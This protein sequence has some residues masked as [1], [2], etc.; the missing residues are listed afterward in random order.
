MN[1]KTVKQKQSKSMDMRFY[2][3]QDRVEQGQFRIFWAP[4]KTN[5][6]DYQ[7]KVQPTSVHQ[8]VRPLYLYIEGKS[9]TTLQ[10]CDKILESLASGTNSKES[11]TSQYIK[12]TAQYDSC[13]KAS[14]TQSQSIHLVRNI[15]CP[16][17]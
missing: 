10:G 2:W 12:T 6:A 1:I 16:S 17:E 5:L 15:A 7:S 13:N 3:L 11:V 8:A 9:P 14:H 4:G